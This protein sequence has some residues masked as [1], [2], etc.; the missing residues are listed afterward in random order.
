MDFKVSTWYGLWL[1]VFIQPNVYIGYPI[2]Q[3]SYIPLVYKLLLC[4]K[5]GIETLK[6]FGFIYYAVL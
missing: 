2:P 6:P 1:Y 3:Y 4:L 5:Y